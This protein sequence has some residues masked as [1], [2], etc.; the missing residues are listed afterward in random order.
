MWDS[1]REE[2]NRVVNLLPFRACRLRCRSLPLRSAPMNPRYKPLLLAAFA[3]V[4]VWLLAWAGMR[5]AASSRMTPEKLIAL[6]HETDLARLDAAARAK[7]LQQLADKL[8]T[9]PRDDR[10]SARA[11]QE[12][13]RVWKQ[14]TEAEKGELVERTMPS[15]V[16]QMLT[17]FEQL[18]EDKRRSAI[19]NAIARMR[20]D[21]ESDE[22]PVGARTDREPMSEE[23]QQKV[24]T[25]GLKTFY[26]E[27][28]AQ[29]KAEVAPLLEEMQQAMQSGKMFRR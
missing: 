28:S 18:P 7:K 27:S 10:R 6:L 3:V 26:S 20:A 17:A 23:M 2:G 14:M 24:V 22:S 13:D 9:M 1:W 15:G 21:R 25:T 12:W 16:K 19:T 4:G 8:N 11:D 5:L 29:T